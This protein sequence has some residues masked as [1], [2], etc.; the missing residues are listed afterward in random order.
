[1]PGTSGKKTS[2]QSFRTSRT[3]PSGSNRANRGRFFSTKPARNMSH[4]DMTLGPGNGVVLDPRKRAPS[5]SNSG[6]SS[7]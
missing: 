6:E 7:S 5:W 3:P 1:M 2:K 4:F